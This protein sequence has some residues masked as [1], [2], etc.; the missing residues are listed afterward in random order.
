MRHGSPLVLFRTSGKEGQTLSVGPDAHHEDV[1]TLE[2]RFNVGLIACLV[3][4]LCFWAA[5]AFG[6]FYLFA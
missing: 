2:E 6:L 1:F 4:C 5:F 3:A